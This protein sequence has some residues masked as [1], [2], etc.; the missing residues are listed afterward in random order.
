[1]LDLQELPVLLPA[2]LLAHL[3]PTSTI[4]QVDNVLLL[5][6]GPSLIA[7]SPAPAPS[8]NS[9]IAFLP[10]QTPLL[11]A[12]INPLTLP[13]YDCPHPLFASWSAPSPS[14]PHISHSHHNISYPFS[15]LLSPSCPCPFLARLTICLLGLA[16]HCPPQ[17][18]ITPWV[19]SHLLLTCS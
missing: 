14:Q 9:T 11:L 15:I 2:A 18:S 7:L 5:C 12:F 16:G 8:V 17:S 10:L 4:L 3:M 6:A 13:F 1:M 19:Y